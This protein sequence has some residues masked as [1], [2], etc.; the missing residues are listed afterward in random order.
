MQQATIRIVKN[1]SGCITNTGEHQVEIDSADSVTEDEEI[2]C[3]ICG[4]VLWEPG[5]DH[6]ILDNLLY[7]CG[8]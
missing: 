7:D 3:R 1:S 5:I 8:L 6:A 2:R 4:L